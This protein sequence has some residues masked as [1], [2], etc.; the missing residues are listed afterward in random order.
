MPK[1]VA[2]TEL[3]NDGPEAV[4]SY[5]PII[6]C[7]PGSHPTEYVFDWMGEDRRNKAK[8]EIELVMAQAETANRIT[9]SAAI[10]RMRRDC[11]ESLGMRHT[12]RT[13]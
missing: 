2:K 12:F 8:K 5:S 6:H 11:R 1:E 3:D 10:S 13:L 7:Q 4:R 9:P